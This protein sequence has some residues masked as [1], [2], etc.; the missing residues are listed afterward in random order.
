MRLI[1][2]EKSTTS[3]ERDALAY[4]IAKRIGGFGTVD[5]VKRKKKDATSS[6]SRRI[7]YHLR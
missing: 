1:Y 7:T 3:A 6:I 5:I 4:K 2:P